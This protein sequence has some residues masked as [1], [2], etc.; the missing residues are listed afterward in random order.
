MPNSLMCA[1]EVKIGSHIQWSFTRS[2]F[3][4]FVGPSGLNP[5]CSYFNQRTERHKNWT[6]CFAETRAEADC[7]AGLLRVDEQSSPQSLSVVSS[8]SSAPPRLF[9]APLGRVRVRETE[10]VL[11]VSLVCANFPHSQFV[12][13]MSFLTFFFFFFSFFHFFFIYFFSSLFKW[14]FVWYC[15][16]THLHDSGENFFPHLLRF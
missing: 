16:W 8:A 3:R 10:R 13:N 4:L 5:E 2:W 6:S 1:A 11:P 9:S 14:C 15:C 12:R 7:V